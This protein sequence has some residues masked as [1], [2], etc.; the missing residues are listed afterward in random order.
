MQIITETTDFFLGEKTAV[1]IGKFDGVHIGHR[2]LLDKLLEQKQSGKKACVFTFDP[3]PAVF[4]KKIKEKELTTKAEKRLLFEKM[5]I[6]ILIEFPMNR[7]TAAMP[8]EEFVQE[9]LFHRMQAAYVAAGSDLSFGS[10]GAGNAVLL[11]KMAD[12]CGVEVSIIDKVLLQGKEVSS[13]YARSAVEQGDM[14]LAEKLLGMPYSVEGIVEHGNHMG[15]KMGMPTVNLLPSADKLLPPAGVYYAGIYLDGRYYKGISN[16]GYKPTIE[17]QEKRLGVET[18]LYDYD[19]NAYGKSITVQLY[20]FKRPE[21]KFESL[22][23]L[24]KQ[25][26]E[27]IT[28]GRKYCRQ[29]TADR[30]I[31]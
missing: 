16:I 31:R 21:Q 19:G 15:H 14:E 30:K 17:E 18:Y 4:F 1:A 20:A 10:R 11:Q 8:P 26:K 25:V 7:N 5:G 27:D 22:K 9:I 29:N 3:P 2:C 28:A 6:D 13:T 24:Q 12:A 23:A